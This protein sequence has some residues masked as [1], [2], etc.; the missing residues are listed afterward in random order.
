MTK[1]P[2]RMR[3][4][5]LMNIYNALR[6][7][8]VREHVIPGAGLEVQETVSGRVISLPRV[9]LEAGSQPPRT[10]TIGL[11]NVNGFWVDQDGYE[12]DYVEV[13]ICIGGTV[14]RGR[15]F[16]GLLPP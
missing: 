15:I 13:E 16:L 3:K 6:D 5:I 1:L 9:M 7:F 10:R 8:V 2:P 4:G 14:R 11:K 12:I